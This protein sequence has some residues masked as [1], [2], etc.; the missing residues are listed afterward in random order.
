MSFELTPVEKIDYL[1]FKRDDMFCP[2]GDVNGGKVRQLIKLFDVLGDKIRRE[3][4]SGVI[5]SASVHS[6]TGAVVARVAKEYGFKCIVAVGGLKEETMHRHDQMKLAR[7]YGAEIRIVSGTGMNTVI[8][9][10]IK[11]IIAENNYWETCFD[12]NINLYPDLMYDTN[13]DQVENIPD[14]LDLLIMPVGVGIQ[15]SCVL[16]GLAKFGKRPKRIVGIEIGPD[17]RKRI[18]KQIAPLKTEYELYQFGGQYSKELNER[19][20]GFYLDPLYEAKAYRWLFKN[21]NFKKVK[22]LVWL[23]GRKLSKQE[24]NDVCQA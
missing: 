24:V 22:T 6:P 4:N 15:F 9:S 11:D 23:V 19:I 18:D 20:N 16:R 21:I 17:R 14:D 1:W 8:Q 2:Y 12:K 10:R 13:A 7:H 3:H 5:V